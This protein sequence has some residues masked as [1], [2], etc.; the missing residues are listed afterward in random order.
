MFIGAPVPLIREARL[1]QMAALILGIACFIP[2]ALF[3]GFFGSGI[4][5]VL[6]SI[7][8]FTAAGATVARYARALAS[9]GDPGAKDCGDRRPW[10]AISRREDGT[11]RVPA[12]FA[13]ATLLNPSGHGRNPSDSSAAARVA[14]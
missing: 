9:R 8:L 5:I 3:F 6:A 7:A 2:F 13:S 14:F 10:A 1:A 11:S 12:L 4:W